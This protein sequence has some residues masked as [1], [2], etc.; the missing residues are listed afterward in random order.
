MEFVH[1]GRTKAA[2]GGCALHA[3]TCIVSV[4]FEQQLQEQLLSEARQ[5]AETAQQQRKAASKSASTSQPS[6]GQQHASNA[7][8]GNKA[9][10]ASSQQVLNR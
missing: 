1:A 2:T 8:S 4:A 5:A 3:S 10:T 7:K 6:S 9:F